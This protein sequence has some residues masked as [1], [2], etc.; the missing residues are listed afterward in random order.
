MGVQFNLVSPS[1]CPGVLPNPPYCRGSQARGGR[2]HGF[3]G[4]AAPEHGAA[5]QPCP[6]RAAPAVAGVS[7]PGQAGHQQQ[8]SDNYAST[9]TCVPVSIH[10]YT[11][12]LTHIY[13]SVCISIYI[14]HATINHFLTQ[15]PPPCNPRTNDVLSILSPKNQCKLPLRAIW[16]ETSHLPHRWRP[17]E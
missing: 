12:T 2:P 9:S 8:V 11:H 5:R 13:R 1:F 4:H 14:S 10:I 17:L 7:T 6:G 16:G 3:L 15:P